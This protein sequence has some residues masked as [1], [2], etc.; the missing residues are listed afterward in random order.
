M[1]L[2][3]QFYPGPGDSSSSYYTNSFGGTAFVSTVFSSGT[4]TAPSS[5]TGVISQGSGVWTPDPL[6]QLMTLSW[7]AVTGPDRVTLNNGLFGSLNLGT[8][9]K[10]I[11]C[12][13]ATLTSGS[14]V[15]TGNTN[16]TELAGSGAIIGQFSITNC[17]AFSTISAGI[18]FL[19]GSVVGS[20]LSLNGNALNANSV[21]HVL[22]SVARNNLVS[23][24]SGPKQIDL[25]GGTSAG[26]SLLT[27][28][29]VTA[30]NALVAAGW[31]VTLNA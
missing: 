7:N 25:S 27:A 11:Q 1:S 24:V 4:F 20:F 9:V 19:P 29:G 21:N 5:A 28:A 8:S 2:L 26:T 17:S 15:P 13:G 16:F 18:E 3:T 14:L 12:N 6:G 30:R 31:T 22:E 10:Y 23:P